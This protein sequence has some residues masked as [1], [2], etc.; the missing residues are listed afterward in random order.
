MNKERRAK[1]DRA[2]KLIDEAV[3]ILTDCA[4]GEQE[5]FDNMPEAI[6]AGEKGT[7]A[8]ETADSL[9]N[10]VSDLEEKIEEITSAQ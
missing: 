3:G 9:E 2:K 5:F 10:I 1:L 8:S 4:E 6:Q 7:K